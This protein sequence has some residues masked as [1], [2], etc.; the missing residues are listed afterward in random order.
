[1]RRRRGGDASATTP[2]TCRGDA[3]A[4]AWIFRG[5]DDAAAATRTH[6]RDRRRYDL[7]TLAACVKNGKLWRS[8]GTFGKQWEEVHGVGMDWRAIASSSDGTRMTAVVYG[9]HVYSNSNSGEGVWRI[10]AD[11]PMQNWVA[12][13]MS[14]TG[15]DVFA[16]AYEGNIWRSYDYGE[17]FRE[18]PYQTAQ[19]NPAKWASLASSA[20][21]YTLLAAEDR[22][23]IWYS[24]DA[25]MNWRKVQV[26]GDATQDWKSL[27][28]SADGSRFGAVVEGSSIWMSPMTVPVYDLMQTQAKRATTALNQ[29]VKLAVDNQCA[30]AEIPLTDIV[31]LMAQINTASAVF[32]QIAANPA[33]QCKG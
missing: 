26:L 23:H 27:T 17:S 28:A 32:A 6:E 8:A 33:S 15:Q 12:I 31:L 9:G 19:F 30:D 4:A 25:G 16:A 20:D 14:A 22:G 21:G 7:D 13:T 3:A 11:T 10:A 1:M 5:H 24:Q 2:R 18:V 29:L